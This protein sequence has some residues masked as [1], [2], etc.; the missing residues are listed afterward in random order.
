[1]NSLKNCLF[2]RQVT[3]VDV[4]L[5]QMHYTQPKLIKRILGWSSVG[6]L[7]VRCDL[8]HRWALC[9]GPFEAREQWASFSKPIMPMKSDGAQIQK[10][11]SRRRRAGKAEAATTHLGE[12]RSPVTAAQLCP[13]SSF[14]FALTLYYY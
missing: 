9:K 3:Q 5:I 10:W 12:R 6:E 1:M 2:I 14:I 11:K 13:S 4:N 8:M 7:F